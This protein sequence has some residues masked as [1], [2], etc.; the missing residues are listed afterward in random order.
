MIVDLR[1]PFVTEA[2]IE[3]WACCV[4]SGGCCTRKASKF[5]SLLD[6][7][8][9]P[10][11]YLVQVACT[12]AP[13]WL[14]VRCQTSEDDTGSEQ[15]CRVRYSRRGQFKPRRKPRGMSTADR[16]TDVWASG[17]LRVSQ[18]P[19][20]RFSASSTRGERVADLSFIASLEL[21]LSALIVQ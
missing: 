21:H 10:F 8:R 9:V 6:L 16:R 18:I 15:A 20:A 5:R 12:T 1:S 7:S 17:V 3:R 2:T 4:Y 19:T 13:K 14:A 11:E